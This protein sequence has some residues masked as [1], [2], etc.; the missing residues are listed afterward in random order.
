MFA[1]GVT[2]CW[3]TVRSTTHGTPACDP[4]GVELS[5]TVAQPPAI[6]AAGASDGED[7][8]DDDELAHVGLLS[9]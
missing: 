1:S 3:R 2:P 5:L 7:G 4:A 8:E 6:A 9:V